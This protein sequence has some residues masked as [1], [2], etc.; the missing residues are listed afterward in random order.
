MPGAVRL[1][2][3]LAA[4]LLAGQCR[5]LDL[6]LD[7]WRATLDPATL[8]VSASLTNQP[9][10]GA[11]VIAAAGE[12]HQVAALE[13]G[14]HH[15]SWRLTDIGVNVSF[16]SDGRRL[17]ARFI[18]KRDLKLAWPSTGD[19]RF[20]AL[21]LPE[22]E[23][24]Y[25]PFTAAAWRRRLAGDCEKLSGV[26]SMPFWSFTTGDRTLTY[27]VRSELRSELCL[28]ERDG[29]VDAALTH[30]FQR[31][32]GDRVHE[33]EIWFGG[34]SPIAPALEY[35]ERLRAAGGWRSLADKIRDNPE[36]A[37]LA[38][39]T[40]FYVWGDGRK[41]Q[42]VGDL[43]AAG[44]RRAWIG[45]DQDE[46]SGQVL[47]GADFVAAA[48]AAGF[49]VGPYDSFANAQDPA[50]G[51]AVSRWPGKLYP[52][53]CIIRRDG[54][55]RRGFANRGCELSSEA[56]VRAEPALRPLA[57]R[58]DRQLRD[59]ANSYFLDV[60][61]FGEL[62]D[63][64]APMH[65]MTVFRDRANRLQ[66]LAMARAR[67]VVLGS[68][69]G[70]AWSVALI[71]FAHG[72]FSVR[73]EVLW[74]E[75]KSFGRWWPPDRPGIFFNPVE[76]SAEFRASKFDPAFRLP[77][78]EAA[79]HDVLVATDRWDL[80]MAQ[81]PSQAATRQLLELLYGVPSIWAM[82]RRLLAQWRASLV[83]LLAF[84]QPLHERIATLP[85]TS[86]EWLTSDRL[87]QRTRFG[88]QVTLTANFAVAEFEGLPSRCIR[89]VDG[90]DER[91]FCPV[92]HVAAR[93]PQP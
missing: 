7:G 1:V 64:Y 84:F 85:L 30:D 74:A 89:A 21:I 5:A 63:D 73:N 27:F 62:W 66:R 25:V 67:R 39:A 40:H 56:L 34:A 70:T 53:G 44:A 16:E 90:K 72:A 61:A 54:K 57:A 75:R 46:F 91:T 26:L 76:P 28:A 58:L 20:T 83:P 41:P 45:Y 23:G 15:A 60:D 13:H 36:V 17:V 51:D 12:P 4:V 31:R 82:D 18:A 86:F 43:V 3:A 78:Y 47:A 37:K 48:K 14:A 80:P 71:D 38:G 6:Q 2:A 22:G 35:R 24:L 50:T 8:A 52:E 68:E 77:L 81:F 10:S 55:P 29:R 59:G 65:P 88:E 32:D 33:I 87:V 93:P 69:Q 79:F 92:R 42:F 49:L 11:I 9:D 19:A